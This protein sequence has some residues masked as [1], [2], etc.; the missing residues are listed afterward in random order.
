MASIWY[1]LVS[2]TVVT[3]DDKS[4]NLAYCGEQIDTTK[5][6]SHTDGHSW[7]YTNYCNDPNRF[8]HDKCKTAYQEYQDSKS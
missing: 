4:F 3:V 6:S 8:I 1:H 2:A 5:P 7:M